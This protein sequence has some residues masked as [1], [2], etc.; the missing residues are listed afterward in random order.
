MINNA[1]YGR[2]S[3]ILYPNLI[4]KA[5]GMSGQKTLYLVRHGENPAN[6]TKEMSCRKKEFHNCSISEMVMHWGNGRW[7]GNLIRWADATH[8]YGEAAE[9]VSGLP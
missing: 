6:I 4:I 7:V 8:L 2:S 5:I 9:L 3:F 1:C